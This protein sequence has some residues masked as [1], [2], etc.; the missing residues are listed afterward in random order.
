[1]RFLSFFSSNYRG[2]SANA[3]CCRALAV[4]PPLELNHKAVL[5]YL[6]VTLLSPSLSSRSVYKLKGTT[7]NRGIITHP[8]LPL[9]FS[10][11]GSSPSLLPSALLHP[12]H[13]A[14][15][16]HSDRLHAPVLALDSRFEQCGV[17][18]DEHRRRAD[19][20]EEGGDGSCAASI[21]SVTVNEEKGEKERGGNAP[22]NHNTGS[23]TTSNTM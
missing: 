18:E 2:W 10:L 6:V 13:T 1:M 21:P 16:P 17:A 12:S 20:P 22:A 15:S 23:P 8:T 11:L 3:R 19:K 9:L 5:P 7:Q 4:L 14:S